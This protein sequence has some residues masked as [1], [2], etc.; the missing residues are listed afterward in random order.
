MPGDRAMPSQSEKRWLIVVVLVFGGLGAAAGFHWLS[1]GSIVIREGETRVGV[2]G[3][4][5]PPVPR[6]NA[7]AAG[8]ITADDAL[9]YPLCV[10]WIA[11]GITMLTLVALAVVTANELFLRLSAYCCVV[12]L[13][14]AFGTVAAA[15]WSGP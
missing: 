5:P 14:L 13:L 9:Y 6:P 4:L 7:R 8:T 15:L 11:L 1:S 2:G 3:R 10:T 12:Y